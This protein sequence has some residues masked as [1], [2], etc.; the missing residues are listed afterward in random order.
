MAD[1]FIHSPPKNSALLSDRSFQLEIL[2]QT[3]LR[4]FR[5]LHAL[6]PQAAR[7][8]EAKM[9]YELARARVRYDFT[10]LEAFLKDDVRWKPTDYDDI[11]SVI[12]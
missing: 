3:A 10:N 6:Q 7:S 5:R 4:H 11:A 9:A 12:L 1:I 2:R 8:T